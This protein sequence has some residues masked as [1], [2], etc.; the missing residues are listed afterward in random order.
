MR[1]EWGCFEKDS[2]RCIP[3]K[4]TCRPPN[5]V[6]GIVVGTEGRLQSVPTRCL[7]DTLGAVKRL[8]SIT[9]GGIVR[10]TNGPSRAASDLV[11]GISG[12]GQVNRV[13]ER[14]LFSIR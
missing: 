5:T 3:D 4:G 7:V 10:P 8:F 11:W 12:S 9:S 1:F 6:D 2:L 14:G 13:A